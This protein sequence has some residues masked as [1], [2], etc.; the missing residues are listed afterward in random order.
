M[1]NIMLLNFNEIRT[2]IVTSIRCFICR[3]QIYVFIH[4]NFQNKRS[5]KQT[6]IRY[7]LIVN[8]NYNET[9]CMSEIVLLLSNKP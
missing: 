6:F 2:G 3:A 1:L 9:M 7:L 8:K 4:L 5:V